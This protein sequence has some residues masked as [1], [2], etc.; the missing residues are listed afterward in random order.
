MTG[1][2]PI[3][4]LFSLTLTANVYAYGKVENI[5]NCAKLLPDG[6][7]YR[8]SIQLNVD[9]TQEPNVFDGDFAV[10]G[11]IEEEQRGE[12]QPFVECVG[13]LIKV[14]VEPVSEEQKLEDLKPLFQGIVY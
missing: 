6:H 12:I 2:K 7:Q 4:A 5:E 8:V 10:G 13:P 3:F 11:D 14:Q 9:K 1:I